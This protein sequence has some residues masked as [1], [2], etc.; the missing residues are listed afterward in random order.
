MPGESAPMRFLGTTGDSD[1]P[2][3][4]GASEGTQSVSESMPRRNGK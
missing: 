4:L 2:I 1:R 3:G